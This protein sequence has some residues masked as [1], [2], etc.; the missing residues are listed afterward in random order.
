VWKAA[1]GVYEPVDG[2]ADVLPSADRFD[3][4]GGGY[5]MVAFKQIWEIWEIDYV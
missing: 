2:P 4:V 3:E 5:D 1:V